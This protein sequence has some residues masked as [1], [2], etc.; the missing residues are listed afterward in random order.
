[1]MVGWFLMEAYKFMSDERRAKYMLFAIIF[2]VLLM[3]FVQYQ[4]A[5]ELIKYKTN[6]YGP[7]KDA[8]TWIKANSPT[9]AKV[10]SISYPQTVYYSERNVSTYS[11]IHSAEEFKQYLI[12]NKP[13]FLIVSIFEPHD[14]WVFNWT[15]EQQAKGNVV[16]V[17]GYFADAA[18]TQPTLIVYFINTIE[19]NKGE[20]VSI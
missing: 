19:Q 12:E 2:I 20:L 13:Q 15:A 6:S 1:M 17:Q 7:V 4:H 18:Q 16:P 9:S 8:S 10:L 11:R 5:D 3:M 14:A